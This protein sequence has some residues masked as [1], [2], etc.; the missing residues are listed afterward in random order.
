MADYEAALQYRG[1]KEIRTLTSDEEVNR[2]LDNGNWDILAVNAYPG[3]QEYDGH[4]VVVV[5]RVVR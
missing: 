5:G 4:P 2:F 3:F 1:V